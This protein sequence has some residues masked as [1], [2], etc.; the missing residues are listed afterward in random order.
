MEIA[1][2]I[3]KQDHIYAY[4]TVR[5]NRTRL[6]KAEISDKQMNHGQFE[7][8][9]SNTGISW[10]K[11]RDKKAVYFL[12]NYHDLRDIKTVDRSEKMAL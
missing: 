9:T 2:F 12:S 4:G 1:M 3:L 10:V 11:W 7:F 6:L 5:S 8:Q